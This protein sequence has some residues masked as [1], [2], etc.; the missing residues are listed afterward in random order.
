MQDPLS[1][2]SPTR[3]DRFRSSAVRL[4]LAEEGIGLLG[5]LQTNQAVAV[6]VDLAEQMVTEEELAP[7]NESI[8][9][10]VHLLEPSR[11]GSRTTR[12]ALVGT[13]EIATE[14]GSRAAK[15]VSSGGAT[16]QCQLVVA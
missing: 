13:T 10:A 11:P 14:Q 7:R 5:F 8:A 15:R 12:L 3:L 6:E 4:T 9:I 2:S 1:S 16:S